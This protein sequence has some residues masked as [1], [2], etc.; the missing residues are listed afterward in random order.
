MLNP[1]LYSLSALS[2]LAVYYT[3]NLIFLQFLNPD[4]DYLLFIIWVEI[5]RLRPIHALN[6]PP[7]ISASTHQ[8]SHEP[9]ATS[10]DSRSNDVGYFHQAADIVAFGFC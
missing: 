4:I 8:L 6:S 9:R 10:R 7:L 1:T 5:L 3:L 2:Y